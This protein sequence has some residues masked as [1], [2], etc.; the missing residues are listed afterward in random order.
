MK[1]TR[2]DVIRAARAFAKCASKCPEIAEKAAG[3]QFNF[4]SGDKALSM[5]SLGYACLLQAMETGWT[6]M[7]EPE[8][9]WEKEDAK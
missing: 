1:T 6:A 3:I 7:P 2:T 4:A 5:L 8:T 9:E